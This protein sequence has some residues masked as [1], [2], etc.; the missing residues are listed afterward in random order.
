M[1]TDPYLSG[2]SH[3]IL[4]E[5]HERDVISDFIITL[6]KQIIAR[7]SDLKLILMSATLN[8]EQFC[9]YYNNCRSINIPGFTYP[10]KSYYLEDVLSRVNFNFPPY[11]EVNNW[12]R[13]L[14]HEKAKR[15]VKQEFT[16]FIEPYVRNMRAKKKYS[17]RVCDNLLSPYSEEINI[18]LIRDLIADICSKEQD[19]GAILV[20]LP[21]Y[22]DICKLNSELLKT[23]RFP[24]S[25]YLIIVLHSKM[26]SIQQRKVFD[27]PA[28]GVRKI[29]IATNIAETSITIDDVVFVIDCGKIKMKSYDV[30]NNIE[31]LKP[32]WVS[33]A[34]A[35][36]RKGRAGR[37]QPGVCFHLFSRPREMCLESYQKPEIQRSSLENIILTVKILQL[38]KAEHFLNKLMDPPLPKAIDN[39]RSSLKHMNALDSQERLTPLGYHL[40]RLPVNPRMG[41]MI[42]LGTI[43]SCLDPVLSI[44]ASLDFKDAFQIP[45]NK[46][47]E[48]DEKKRELLSGWKSDHLVLAE[49]LHR[50]EK[51]KLQNNERRFCWEYFLS[52]YTLE[53]LTN[54]KDQ[55]AQYL[56]D[57]NFLADSNVK[58]TKWNQNSS[59]LSLVKAIVCASLYPNV[60]IIRYFIYIMFNRKFHLT[61][62]LLEK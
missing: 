58:N 9:K 39:A 4:D 50:Y 34:N 59:N 44:A 41:K 12:R 55:F 60:A 22:T 3:L 24:P 48:V 21:G 43:F 20:F 18:E 62:I 32:E 1:E 30:E 7:R 57:M 8:A 16:D 47:N 37:V 27:K 42:L 6:L 61:H 15:Q 19:D 2:I 40:A 33:M 49:A 23:N 28:K 10:V 56:C 26:P 51:A 25:N 11:R 13:H 29:V 5:I 52:T 53:L 14:K 36:Q 35:N 17:S 46:Q 45:L 31:S 54:M 38:G